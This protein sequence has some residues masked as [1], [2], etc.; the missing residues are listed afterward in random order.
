MTFH[1]K[2][3]NALIQRATRRRRTVG[4]VGVLLRR[5]PSQMVTAIQQPGHCLRRVGQKFPMAV[6]P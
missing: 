1:R 4:P 5:E 2:A 6:G 3:I